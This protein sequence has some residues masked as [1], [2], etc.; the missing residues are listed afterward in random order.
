MLERDY[1]S[2]LIKRIE[3]RLP[4]CIILKN[5]SGYRQG[6]PDLTVF[7][8]PRYG[9]LE[10]KPE[11]PTSPDDYEPNQ[12]WYINK[13]NE[14]AFGSVIYPGNEERV[15]DALQETLSPSEPPSCNPKR[16]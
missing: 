11:E 5:D 12:E 8:G 1:Q 6:I 14:M 16:E 7:Y 10:V 3:K 4:G 2:R 9:I 15:L 13:F